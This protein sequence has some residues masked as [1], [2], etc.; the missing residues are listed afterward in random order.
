MFILQ[1]WQLVGRDYP[2]AKRIHLILD[3][4]RIHSSLQTKAALARLDGRVVL[5]FLPPYCPDHNRI[6]RVW[7]DLHD[8]V[9]RNHQCRTMKELMTEVYHWLKKRDRTTATPV[10][11]EE[12]CLSLLE[13]RKAI[14]VVPV[15]RSVKGHVVMPTPPKRRRQGSLFAEAGDRISGEYSI[16]RVVKTRRLVWSH[17]V[18]CW[19]STG[20]GGTFKSTTEC[21]FQ[22][23]SATS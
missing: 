18:N 7:R 2:Q 12:S 9:T 1:L 21:S 11:P 10:L 19:Y 5:H 13:S 14:S 17:R 22:P 3:N 16:N 20:S 15:R 6:E 8:N 23:A 4:Y